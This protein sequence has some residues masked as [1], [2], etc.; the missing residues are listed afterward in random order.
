MPSFPNVAVV[1]MHF[2]GQEAKDAAANVALGTELRLQREPENKYDHNALQ[3]FLEDQFLGYIEATQAAWISPHIDAGVL[4]R[5]LVTAKE[6]R[7]NNI[8]PLCLLTDDEVEFN[9]MR[10]FFLDDFDHEDYD[11]YDG[12]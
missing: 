3:V 8:H 1:G 4:I 6:T 2:R 11:D 7:K 9:D 5:C 10:S 12:E